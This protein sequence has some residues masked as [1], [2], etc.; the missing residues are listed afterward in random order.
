MK[1]AQNLCKPGWGAEDRR[2]CAGPG[3]S[4]LQTRASQERPRWV[5]AEPAAPPTAG[6]EA[7]PRAPRGGRPP[8]AARTPRKAPPAGCGPA[9]PRRRA[10]CWQ[11]PLRRLETRSEESGSFAAGASV[12]PGDGLRAS[13]HTEHA[14]PVGTAPHSLGGPAAAEIT[15]KLTYKESF[16]FVSKPQRLTAE[17]PAA[18]ASPARARAPPSRGETRPRNAGEEGGRKGPALAAREHLDAQEPVPKLPLREA[19]RSDLRPGCRADAKCAALPRAA[20]R[21]PR[22]T[23]PAAPSPVGFL[24][25]RLWP[26]L[27]AGFVGAWPR[28]ELRCLDREASGTGLRVLPPPTLAVLTFTRGPAFSLCTNYGAGPPPPRHTH[29]HAFE[30]ARPTPT[31]WPEKEKMSNYQWIYRWIMYTKK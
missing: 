24:P 14:R 1:N 28:Q 8:G 25:R 19:S 13:L 9:P 30:S 17:L 4:G 16:Y 5:P 12:P 26:L 27:S 10:A 21:A 15:D 3:G 11:K 22:P 2:G 20:R 18:E 23:A 6:A 29:T 31:G 7:E